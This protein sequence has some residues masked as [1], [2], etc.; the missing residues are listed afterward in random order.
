M[1]FMRYTTTASDTGTRTVTRAWHYVNRQPGW[2]TRWAM[3]VFL[4][5]IGLPIALLFGIAILGAVLLFGTLAVVNALILQARGLFP[6][7]DGRENVRVMRRD[8]ERLS[9]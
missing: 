4:L 3:L 6:R 1:A 9:D 2:V 8:G 7:K 5:I